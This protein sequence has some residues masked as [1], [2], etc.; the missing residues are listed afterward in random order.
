MPQQSVGLFGTPWCWQRL[1]YI[2]P[3]YRKFHRIFCFSISNILKNSI[4]CFGERMMTEVTKTMLLICAT[5]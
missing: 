3:D 5:L 1:T 2:R 4:P